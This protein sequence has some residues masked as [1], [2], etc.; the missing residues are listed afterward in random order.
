MAWSGEQ[1][2]I[3]GLK[4]SA[5]LT[6]KQFYFVELSGAGTVAVCNAAT[7]KAIGVLQNAPDDGQPAEVCAIGITKVS[8]DGALTRGTLIGPSA[9]GQADGK[10]PGSDSGEFIHGQVIQ[11][12]GAAGQMAVALINCATPAEA[13]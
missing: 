5:D 8:S 12:S 10:T 4:A 2:R 9:D 6:A 7:D 13:D 1:I 3:P 11:A